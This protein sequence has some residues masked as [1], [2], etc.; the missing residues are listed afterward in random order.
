[1]PFGVLKVGDSSADWIIHWALE[2]RAWDEER[3]GNH[4]GLRVEIYRIWYTERD[5]P[6]GRNM[7]PGVLSTDPTLPNQTSVIDNGG[8][9]VYYDVHGDDAYGLNVKWDFRQTF[10]DFNFV[11]NQGSRLYHLARVDGQG[12]EPLDVNSP[13]LIQFKNEKVRGWATHTEFGY[14]W[15]TGRLG[16]RSLYANGDPDRPLDNGRQFLRGLNGFYEITPGAYQGARLYFNGNDSQVDGGGGL[17]HSV[18]NTRMLGGFLEFDDPASAKVGYRTAL[19]DLRHFHGVY[20]THGERQDYIGLEWDN[21]LTWYLHK[22]AHLQFEANLLKQGPAFSYD[23]FTTPDRKTDLIIQGII[24]FVY[25][26]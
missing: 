1:M 20:D 23:D 17:G 4:E 3:E 9:P 15:T 8:N 11:D 24:R 5:V 13:L 19:L 7:A 2:Y 18:T 12:V 21:M 6:L 22:T 16:L 26:F 14:R 25:V 10:L